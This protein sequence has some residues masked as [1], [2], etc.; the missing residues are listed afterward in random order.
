M[1]YKKLTEDE[2]LRADAAVFL[3]ELLGVTFA[4]ATAAKCKENDKKAKKRKGK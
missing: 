1:I 2:V 3:R 4:A